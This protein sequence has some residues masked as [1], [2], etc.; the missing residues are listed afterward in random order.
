MPEPTPAQFEILAN[1]KYYLEVTLVGSRDVMDGYFME[2]QGF[3]RSQEIISIFEVVPE[4]WGSK[5]AKVGRVRQT[6]LPGNSKSDNIILKRG[7]CLSDS[8][9]RWFKAV[10]DGKWGEQF[11]DGDLTIYSQAG[12][13]HARFR[14]FN[15]WPA[16]Y[17]ITDVK[18][19]GTDFEVE[20]VELAVDGF[21]RVQPDGNEIK[22]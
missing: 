14:F 4:K 1:S 5:N 10:E 19:S 17:K 7:L 6:K 9:W 13:V 12:D 8:M 21:V 22:V 3:K 18:S 16:S 11:H 15:A 2:C 20:E